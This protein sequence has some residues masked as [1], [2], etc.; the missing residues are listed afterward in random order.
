[1]TSSFP[2]S[3]L[4]NEDLFVVNR[5][6]R[7]YTINAR[8]IGGWLLQTE[9]PQPCDRDQDCPSGYECVDGLCVRLTCDEENPCP[10]GMVCHNG[11]C[12]I[13]CDPNNPNFCQEG[14]ICIEL[15]SGEHACLEYPT[16]CHPVEGCPDG[17]ICINGFCY[18]DCD[19]SNGICPEGSRC[20]EID[21]NRVCLPIP[22]PCPDHGCPPGFHCYLD[23]CYEICSP[24]NPCPDGQTC[25][26]LPDGSGISICIGQLP[27]PPGGGICNNDKDCPGGFYCVGGIC[28]Q[29]PCTAG[30]E[31][32][33]ICWA[34]F[35]YE[36]CN[37]SA[38]EPCPDGF[39]CVQLP[40][41]ETI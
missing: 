38:P 10:P 40:T 28:V 20:V 5:S 37:P 7:S 15:P 35:C 16:P 26:E 8:D 11:F 27:N 12:Y 13:E 25:V 18:L 4:D 24:S 30:C 17:F 32:G 1:M 34:G 2:P 9:P 36:P 21:G 33:Q 6:D 19:L 3:P 39:E 41:G 31:P 29:R 22:F 14:S 23:M